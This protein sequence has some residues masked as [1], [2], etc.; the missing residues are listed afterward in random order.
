[1]PSVPSPS[2]LVRR[3]IP[4]GKRL[5]HA[6]ATASPVAPRRDRGS[7]YIFEWFC[8]VAIIGIFLA[9]AL[10]AYKRAAGAAKG[11]ACAANLQ[12]LY[13]MT[14]MYA[15][16]FDGIYPPL[17]RDPELLHATRPFVLPEEAWTVRLASYREAK[18]AEKSDPFACPATEVPTYAYNAALGTRVFPEYDPK[19]PP[20]C[21]TDVKITSETFLFFDTANRGA[22]NNLAGWR[23]YAGSDKEPPFRPGDFVLPSRA[24]REDW[25]YPRHNDAVCALYCDGH[26]KRISDLGIRFAKRNPFDPAAE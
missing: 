10:P 16:D 5:T 8:L 2:S 7:L 17:P 12:R 21:E 24:I 1:M 11:T 25:Q 4:K 26:V 6:R 13:Q 19:A 20:T 14:S 18:K 22:A 3:F 23:F 15:Q 9:I